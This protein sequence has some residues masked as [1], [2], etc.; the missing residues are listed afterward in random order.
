VV[1]NLTDGRVKVVAEGSRG[2][3]AA[4]LDRLEGAGV[5]GR[6]ARVTFRWDQ[7]RGGLVGFVER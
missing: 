1:E 6:V 3:C 2:D 4:L 5:P 7:A